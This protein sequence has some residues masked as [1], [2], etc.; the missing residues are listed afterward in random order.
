MFQTLLGNGDG[1]FGRG[2]AYAIGQFPIGIASADFNGDGWP[3]LATVNIDDNTVSLLLGTGNG[4]FAKA[5]NYPVS[6]GQYGA[7]ATADF[8][9]DG[10]QDVAT[11][12]YAA[13]KCQ[14]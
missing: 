12:N 10:Y 1:T 9:G 6:S 13:G 5:T 7:I 4:Q 2:G 14:S 8:N 11:V 3:D